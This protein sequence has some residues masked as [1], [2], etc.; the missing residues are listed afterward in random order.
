M[1]LLYILKEKSSIFA[2]LLTFVLI[3]KYGT[4]RKT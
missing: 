1:A 3:F 2:L 4:I